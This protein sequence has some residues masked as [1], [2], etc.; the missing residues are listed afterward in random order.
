MVGWVAHSET[1]RAPLADCYITSQSAFETNV[2]G[3]GVL[4]GL[5]QNIESS[6]FPE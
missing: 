2:V 4:E 3:F 1:R 6:T 5:D